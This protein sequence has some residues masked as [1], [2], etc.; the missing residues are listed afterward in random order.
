MEINLAT[1]TGTDNFLGEGAE[2]TILQMSFIAFSILVL[3]LIGIKLFGKQ[4][5]FDVLLIIFFGA[6]VARGI[7]DALRF[8]I[9]VVIAVEMIIVIRCRTWF[10]EA[11]RKLTTRNTF[12][13]RMM[14]DL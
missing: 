11:F 13:W 1:I 9:T 5:A 10:M 8:F 3:L 14:K 12:E 7:I 2:L 4:Y 6:V